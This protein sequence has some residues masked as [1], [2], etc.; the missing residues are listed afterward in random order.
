MKEKSGAPIVGM[1]GTHNDIGELSGFTTSGYLDKRDTPYGD[2]AHFNTMPPGMDI[3]NQ[4]IAEI[5]E[6]PM[7]TVVGMSYPG[8]GWTPTPRDVKE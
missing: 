8:D 2:S 3:S 6:M 1:G 4:P 5:H 7:R